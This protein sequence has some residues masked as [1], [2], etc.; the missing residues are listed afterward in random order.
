MNAADG[1]GLNFDEYQAVRGSFKSL[2]GCVVLV[3]R[4]ATP[5]PSSRWG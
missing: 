5:F 4:W 3:Q 2:T 1:A